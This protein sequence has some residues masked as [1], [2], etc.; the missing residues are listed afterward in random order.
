[1]SKKHKKDQLIKRRSAKKGAYKVSRKKKL[2]AK[3]KSEIEKLINA[4]RVTHYKREKLA[5]DEFHDLEFQRLNMGEELK[6]SLIR[7][8][9]NVYEFDGWVRCISFQYSN[10]PLSSRGSI[11]SIGGRFNIGKDI[12][13]DKFTAFNAL[14]LA[15]DQATALMEKFGVAQEKNL[16]K[17]MESCFA[18]KENTTTVH[19]R[20]VLHS[21]LDID[22]KTTLKEF[23]GLISKVTKSTEIQNRR[24]FLGLQS[25]GVIKDIKALKKSLYD[26]EWR[27]D[28]QIYDLPANAQLFGQIAYR[29]GVEAILYSSVKSKK[30]CLAVFPKNLSDRSFI[31]LTGTYPATV[32][33]LKLNSSNYRETL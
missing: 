8:T 4:P 14:Y 9:L 31:E 29:A 24:K 16:D 32:K 17:T 19:V 7:N 6:K 11:N 13:E 33:N 21:V 3:Q 25:G 1:M 18:N 10:Q 20:G 15:Q 5:F 27:L 23:I 22:G 12:S 26:P 2:S 30:K 28:P